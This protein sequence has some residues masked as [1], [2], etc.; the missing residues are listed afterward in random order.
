MSSTNYYIHNV[1]KSANINTH[2]TAQSSA[3]YLVTILINIR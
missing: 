1:G 2:K 3:I